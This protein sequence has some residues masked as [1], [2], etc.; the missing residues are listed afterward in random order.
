V[1]DRL[2]ELQRQRV[3]AQEQLAWLEKEI[4]RE[5][6]QTAPAAHSASAP[7]PRSVTPAPV[8]PPPAAA[9]AE[10]ILAQYQGEPD[11]LHKSVKL[12][13]FLYFFAALGLLVL[14]VTAWYFLRKPH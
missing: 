5:T 6:G 1:S 3:L 12:G 8:T 4:A 10:A 2:T 9:D 7:R 13:C 14:S 11:S